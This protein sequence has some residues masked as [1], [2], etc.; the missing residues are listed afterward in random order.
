[1]GIQKWV[2]KKKSDINGLTSVY[3]SF[4]CFLKDFPWLFFFFFLNGMVTAAQNGRA[5]IPQLEY[6]LD[7]VIK[8]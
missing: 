2:F 1:M 8:L 3:N 7:H 6:V 4:S 5:V